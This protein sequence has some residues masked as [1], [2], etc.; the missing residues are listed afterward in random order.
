MPDFGHIFYA[1]RTCK[2]IFL[3]LRGIFFG[4][5]GPFFG[6]RAVSV[7]KT[8]CGYG[9][10][11]ILVG[12]I[13]GCQNPFLGGERGLLDFHLWTRGFFGFHFFSKRIFSCQFLVDF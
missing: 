4:V 11:L 3:F 8:R 9:V 6:T 1:M 12:G 5:L 2:S 13:F 7:E 10:F